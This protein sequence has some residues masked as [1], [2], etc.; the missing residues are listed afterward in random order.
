[1]KNE[2]RI[3]EEGLSPEQ[4]TKHRITVRGIIINDT[5]EIMMVYSKLY[6]DYT[7]PGGGVKQQESHHEALKRELR[8]EIG[9]HAIEI[10]KE[11][12]HIDEIKHCIRG[13]EDIYLQ[14]SVYYL[15]NVLTFGPIDLN[16]R[17]NIHGVSPVWVTIDEAINKNNEVM[18]DENHR[19][20]GIR[21]VLR[22]ENKILTAIKENQLCA[23][24][25]S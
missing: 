25:K 16:G 4:V 23:D 5:H 1:M 19:K 13:T 15:V 17:E 9:A 2:G 14:H 8:E 21:T 3:I 12:F 20:V 6:D 10:I 22:R 11:C 24:L 7:F 18:H